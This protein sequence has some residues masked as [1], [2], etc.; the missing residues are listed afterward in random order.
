MHER[1]LVL[2][3]PV[4]IVALLVAAPT[5]AQPPL[6]EVARQ[7][8]ERRAS[9]VEK[10]RVYTNDDLRGGQR[11]TTT[12]AAPNSKSPGAIVATTSGASAE[13]RP[14]DRAEPARDAAFWR[15]RITA[16]REARQRA[17][18]IA[19]A[20]QNR[21]DGLWAK[22]T[23]R[24]DPFQRAEIEQDRLDAL[25]ELENTQAELE[26]RDQELLDLQEEARR[27]GVPP[28]WLR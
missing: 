28:G 16:A 8:I 20:L 3:L 5:V 23:A 24:D 27:A 25:A 21:V 26:Q 7:E 4:A 22:F 6:A 19:A 1:F 18:L 17:A 2:G 12:S 11:L 9:I 15:E 10:S 13:V 14:T